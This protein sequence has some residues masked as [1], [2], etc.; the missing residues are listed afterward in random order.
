VLLP[1]EPL[2]ERRLD[3]REPVS[4]APLPVVPVEPLP[5]PVVPVPERSFVFPKL[6]GEVELPLPVP[7]PVPVPVLDRLPLVSPGIPRP[8]PVPSPV[9]PGEGVPGEVVLGALPIPGP[10]MLLPEAPGPV[11]PTDCASARPGAINP[12]R[13]RANIVFFM[14]SSSSRACV[15]NPGGQH[16][17][18]RT[19]GASQK[20]T[21]AIARR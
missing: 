18:A 10:G 13:I 15:P 3:G 11:P 16:F 12:E 1:E 8:A 5:V 19:S 14:V 2:R 17:K 21:A 4:L 7:V 20:P 9:V 6:P